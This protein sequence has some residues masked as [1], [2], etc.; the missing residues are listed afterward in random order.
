MGCYQTCGSTRIQHRNRK[1]EAISTECRPGRRNGAVCN[2]QWQLGTSDVNL[3]KSLFLPKIINKKLPSKVSRYEYL[4]I[5]LAKDRFISHGSYI[6]ITTTYQN[7][8]I[9]CDTAGKTL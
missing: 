3:Q 6:R 2:A 7:K 4:L 5:R 9:M 8:Y 1:A